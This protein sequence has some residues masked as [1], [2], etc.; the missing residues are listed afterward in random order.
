[1]IKLKIINNLM[2]NNKFNNKINK[3]GIYKED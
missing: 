1:M 2:M 3:K